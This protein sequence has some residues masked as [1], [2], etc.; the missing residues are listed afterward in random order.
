MQLRPAQA[1]CFENICIK[2]EDC[3]FGE[4]WIVGV[5][6]YTDRRQISGR[7]L[8]ELLSS[9]SISN[10]HRSYEDDRVNTQQPGRRRRNYTTS[11]PII[12]VIIGRGPT[13]LRRAGSRGQTRSSPP[14]TLMHNHTVLVFA[15]VSRQ[16]W[17][18]GKI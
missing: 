6:P 9:Y 3:S 17:R 13:Q 10:K 16:W 1:D 8:L 15:V 18:R 7:F 2:S 11:P 14:F 12:I 4:D 5:I